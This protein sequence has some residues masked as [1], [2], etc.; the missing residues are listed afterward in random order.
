MIETQPNL[1]EQ[2]ADTLGYF[3]QQSE[4]CTAHLRDV[5]I[6]LDELRH[7]K[8]HEYMLELRRIREDFNILISHL[9]K[10]GLPNLD[11]YS[12]KLE[13]VKSLVD[14]PGWPSAVNPD[15]LVET[16]EGKQVRAKQ[17]LDLIVTEFLEGLKFLDYGCGEG[18]TTTEACADHRKAT[19]VIGYDIEKQWGYDAAKMTTDLAIVEKDAPYDIALLYDVLDH[20]E[21][22]VLELVRV[23]DVLSPMGRVYLRMHPWCGKHGGHLYKTIN[24]AYAHIMFDEDE[25][26]RLFGIAG[27]FVQK[28]TNPISTYRDWFFQAGFD[29]IQESIIRDTELLPYFAKMDNIYVQERMSM[30]WKEQDPRKV[31]ALNF[32]NYVLE[33]NHSH[34]HVF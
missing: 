10:C 30:Y 25:Q 19:K 29:I 11:I 20:C 2:Y 18:F 7:T 23:R 17:I 31:L 14:D 8:E 4:K 13:R 6:S 12:E 15:Y 27:T 34:K 24:K 1:I 3:L 22:P 5:K 21:N 26:M 16:T 32:V 33:P 9:E 28:L